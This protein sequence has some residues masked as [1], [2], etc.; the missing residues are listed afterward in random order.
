MKAVPQMASQRIMRWAVLLRAY[1]YV[2]KYREGKNNSNADGLSRL[3]LPENLPTEVADEEQVLMVDQDQEGVM[4][5]EQLQRWTTKDPILS[6]VREYALRGWPTIQ[7]PNFQPYRQRQ[8]ELSVQ[9][10][11]VLWG[12]R[13]VIPERGRRPLLEQLHPSHPGMSHM[14]G[15]ARSYM[16]WPHM[17]TDIEEK[18]VTAKQDSQRPYH[19]RHPKERMFVIGDTVYTRNYGGGPKWIPGLIQEMTGP[20]SYLVML[21]NGTGVRRHVDQLFAH[22]ELC[23]SA[24]MPEGHPGEPPK[25]AP[26]ISAETGDSDERHMEVQVTPV[27]KPHMESSDLQESP[28]T[29]LRRSQ[30]PKRPP[31]HLRDFVP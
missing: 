23:L 19:D 17:E 4:T 6:R 13:V 2:I 16:W 28:A 22:L 5:S 12:A 15:L 29:G 25:A 11:C 1:E 8:Q 26:I 20:V 24:R 21:G 10:G 3:P 14:K 7:H 27:V 9:D 31:E 30:R 18:K